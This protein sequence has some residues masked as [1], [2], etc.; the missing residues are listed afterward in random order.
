MDC[1]QLPLVNGISF[2][3]TK[4]AQHSSDFEQLSPF[5]IQPPKMA[6]YSASVASLGRRGNSLIAIF[7]RV[8]MRQFRGQ[9]HNRLCGLR[10][11]PESK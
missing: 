5:P 2:W 10:Q 4:P 3:Q 11:M 9:D 6:A 8:V 7:R 1:V